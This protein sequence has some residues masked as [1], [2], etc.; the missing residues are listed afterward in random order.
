MGISLPTHPHLI[1]TVEDLTDMLDYNSEGIDGMDDDAEEE[2][3]QNPP[4]IG[5]WT[6]TPS[7]DV[8]MVD[9]PKENGND[10][11]EDSIEDK[12]PEIQSKR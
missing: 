5:G 11:K 4:F 9:T 8:Y 7:Y 12:H 1:A 3:A 2:Q 10:D 6:T